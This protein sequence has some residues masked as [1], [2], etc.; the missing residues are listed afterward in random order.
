MPGKEYDAENGFLSDC[1]IPDLGSLVA[2]INQGS[3]KLLPRRMIAG[4]KVGQEKFLK[5]A[6]TMQSVVNVS[7]TNVP[8]QVLVISIS[9]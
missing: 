6:R 3:L 8:P 2:F 1:Q 4:R 5:L 7:P 9:L